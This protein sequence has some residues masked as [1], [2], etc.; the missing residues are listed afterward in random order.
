M[1]LGLRVLV[2]E[3]QYGFILGHRV[4]ARETDDQVAIPV[5]TALAQRFPNLHSISMDK[6]FHSPTK[7]KN[8]PQ[9]A[10]ENA[11]G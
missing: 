8:R 1:E 5:V 7:P 4:M 11:T 3:D 6:G 2:S 9:A 10:S